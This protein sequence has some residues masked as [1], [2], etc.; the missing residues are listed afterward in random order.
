[1]SDDDAIPPALLARHPELPAIHAALA[2]H[3]LGVPITTPCPT[4]DAT[5][6]V[7]AVPTVGV[8]VVTCPGGHVHYRQK[9]APR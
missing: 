5:L 6:V 7:T 9:G 2:E 8:I 4:C 1:V 3:H